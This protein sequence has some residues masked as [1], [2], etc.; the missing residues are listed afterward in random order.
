MLGTIAELEAY[1]VPPKVDAPSPLGGMLATVAGNQKHLG[2]WTLTD[3][4][5]LYGAPSSTQEIVSLLT[6]AAASTGAR[7]EAAEAGRDFPPPPVAN[8]VTN[9]AL[10]TELREVTAE[11]TLDASSLPPAHSSWGQQIINVADEGIR[12]AGRIVYIAL[13]VGLL[14]QPNPFPDRIA[15]VVVAANS[16]SYKFGSWTLEASSGARKA[17][18]GEGEE[19]GSWDDNNR[20]YIILPRQCFLAPGTTGDVACAAYGVGWAHD[21]KLENYVDL[22]SGRDEVRESV[23]ELFRS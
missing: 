9:I 23:V 19:G 8:P 10:D 14:A 6:G 11:H 22:L 15:A 17:T 5:S 4:M 20:V 13:R 12:G 18:V 21:G 1:Y 2:S 3:V 16:E 7:E